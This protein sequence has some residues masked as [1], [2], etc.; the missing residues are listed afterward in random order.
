MNPPFKDTDFRKASGSG[1]GDCVEVAITQ[2]TPELVG[3]RD[4]K[5]PRSAVLLLAPGEW[6]ALTGSAR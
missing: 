4:S 3:L 1:T 2:H 5:N 6:L